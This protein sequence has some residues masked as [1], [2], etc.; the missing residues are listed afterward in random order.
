[1][2]TVGRFVRAPGIVWVPILAAAATGATAILRGH[3]VTIDGTTHTARLPTA[4]GDRV[5]GVALSDADPDTLNVSVGVKG[6]YTM[7]MIPKTGDT[8]FV[9]TIVYQDQT[10]FG[11]ITTSL[12]AAKEVGWVVHPQKDS[13]GNLE[14]AFFLF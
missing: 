1:M 3:L 2:S 7:S 13:L 11:Q 12:T 5:L 14:I 4:V 10:A 9:G 8:F 6:G